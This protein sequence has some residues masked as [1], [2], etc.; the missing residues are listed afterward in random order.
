MR[1]ITTYFTIKL[2]L[3][4]AAPSSLFVQDQKEELF[5]G[6]HVRLCSFLGMAHIES[7]ALAHQFAEACA[8]SL[9]R[10]YGDET[11]LEV[12]S[13]EATEHKKLAV[14]IQKDTEVVRRRL[15]AG[16]FTPNKTP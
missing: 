15:V 3:P 2:Q 6:P 8:P 14:R 13:W 11:K 4:Q 10:R 7:A 1:Q 16:N 9:Q 12:V 5:L